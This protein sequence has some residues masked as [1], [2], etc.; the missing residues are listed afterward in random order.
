MSQDFPVAGGPIPRGPAAAQL[1]DRLTPTD[2]SAVHPAIAAGAGLI[3]ERLTRG[4]VTPLTPG[5]RSG[6]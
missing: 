4:A 5:E 6:S 3:A 2:P 1:P